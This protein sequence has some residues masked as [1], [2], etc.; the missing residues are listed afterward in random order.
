[1]KRT[2]KVHTI[3]LAAQQ[4]THHRLE[5]TVL[6]SFALL[7][8]EAELQPELLKLVRDTGGADRRCARGKYSARRRP[9]QARSPPSQQMPQPCP[10]TRDLGPACPK[11][12]PS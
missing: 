2:L 4:E 12:T 3:G 10:P 11:R 9:L 7:E 6:K 8:A 1:M 5:Y